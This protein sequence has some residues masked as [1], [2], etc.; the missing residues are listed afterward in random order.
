MS[1]IPFAPFGGD[2]TL[3][4]LAPAGARPEMASRRNSEISVD[5]F[6]RDDRS[7]VVKVQHEHGRRDK[8]NYA[9]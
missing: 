9:R 3:V 7:I 1:L 4:D 6:R 8:A 5:G 2:V